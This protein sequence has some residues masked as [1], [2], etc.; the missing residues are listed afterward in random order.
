[1]QRVPCALGQHRRDRVRQRPLIL[2]PHDQEL[3]PA[4]A[5]G[6][7]GELVHRP[8]PDRDLRQQ[9]VRPV[10][11]RRV[12]GS[13]PRVLKDVLGQV[14]RPAVPRQLRGAVHLQPDVGKG[15]LK[16][17]E[18]R[19][20]LVPRR[21]GNEGI[22]EP[23]GG[24]VPRQGL[25][26]RIGVASVHETVEAE[27]LGGGVEWHGG[28]GGNRGRRVEIPRGI[29]AGGGAAAR[30]RQNRG[31]TCRVPNHVLD[32]IERLRWHS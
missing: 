31:P 6:A 1:M 13:E 27:R 5:V 16:G 25:C 24:V 30:G 7:G 21:D 26:L 10:V 23:R 20:D 17:V 4:L 22:G 28:F 3:L 8:G 11:L 12:H 19:G 14:R 9:P 2:V 29:C 18:L 15:P 32:G